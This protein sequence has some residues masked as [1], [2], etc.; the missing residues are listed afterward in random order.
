MKSA[1]TAEPVG[2]P[3]MFTLTGRPRGGGVA[4]SVGCAAALGFAGSVA[5]AA[6]GLAGGSVVLALPGCAGGSAL[7]SAWF[8]V[9]FAASRARLAGVEELV[10]T[11]ITA[12]AS[13]TRT[14]VAIG[15]L[16]LRVVGTRMGAFLRWP[17][18]VGPR[19]PRP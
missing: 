6:P 17:W 1:G 7:A 2:R 18:R 13:A 3:P 8:A 5:L 4:S 16:D 9:P 10:V 19:D 11:A 15:S 14:A 12:T